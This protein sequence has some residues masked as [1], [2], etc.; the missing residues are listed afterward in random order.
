MGVR[1]SQNDFFIEKRIF[2]EKNKSEKNVFLAPTSISMALTLLL[3]G[4]NGQTEIEMKKA[5]GYEGYESM[6]ER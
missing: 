6:K 2:S 1:K 3:M 5:L 4:A